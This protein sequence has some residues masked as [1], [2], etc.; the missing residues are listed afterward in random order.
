VNIV[1][2]PNPPRYTYC[3]QIGH[4]INECSFIEDNVKQRFVEHFQNL[5]LELARVED[6][7]DFELEDLYHE[8][9]RILYRFRE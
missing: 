9:V 6:H 3:H 7:G 2:R 4:H 8:R 1:P 5:N